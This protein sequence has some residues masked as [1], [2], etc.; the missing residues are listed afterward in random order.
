MKGLLDIL[1]IRYEAVIQ[2]SNDSSFYNNVHEYIDWIVKNPELNEIIEISAKDYR[3]KHADIWDGKTGTFKDSEERTRQTYKLEKFSLYA[4]SF[5]ILESRI[6]FPLEDYKTTNDPDY[7]QD[8]AVFLMLRDIKDIPRI[9]WGKLKNELPNR[10]NLKNLINLNKWYAGMREHYENQ[11]KQ[12]HTDFLTAIEK[13]N[14]DNLP[15]INNKIPLLFNS[16]TGDFSY[17]KTKGKI[18]LGTNEF[19]IFS[20]LYSRIGIFVDHL[21][22]YKALNTNNTEVRKSQKSALSQVIRNIKEKLEI[23]PKDKAI[24]P[25]IFENTP[26]GGYRLIFKDKLTTTE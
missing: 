23:L 10:W 19:K 18:A 14:K 9:K 22:I 3:I 17:F 12:F 7:A 11:L 26:K 1:K 8:P 16:R 15:K 6:Y 25:D 4:S 20:L 24:N 5:C 21:T 2:S 13:A